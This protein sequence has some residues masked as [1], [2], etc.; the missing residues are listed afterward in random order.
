[1][2]RPSSALTMTEGAP[3]LGIQERIPRV[4]T[5]RPQISVTARQLLKEMTGPQDWESKRPR[6]V[7]PILPPINGIDGGFQERISL[8]ESFLLTTKG[9]RRRRHSADIWAIL[10]ERPAEAPPPTRSRPSSSPP[11]R[12]PR[13]PVTEA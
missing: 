9:H 3:P 7:A 10:R 4:G 11:F 8:P 5:P 1:M 2:A 12:R 13:P 6:L